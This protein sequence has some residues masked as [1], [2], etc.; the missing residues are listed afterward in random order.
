MIRVN[1]S[2]DSLSHQVDTAHAVFLHGGDV[3]ALP[4]CRQC[5]ECEQC[6]D[7]YLFHK[8]IMFFKNVTKV[9]CSACVA[10]SINSS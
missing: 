9:V 1:H 5:D 6:H 10:K 7:D 3:A 4:E 8:V 2:Y